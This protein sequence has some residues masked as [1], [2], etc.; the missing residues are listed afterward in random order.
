MLVD[1]IW[2]FNRSPTVTKLSS[3]F[4]RF[5]VRR[6]KLLSQHGGQ[7]AQMLGLKRCSIIGKWQAPTLA[8]M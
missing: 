4:V 3:V 6:F 2:V 5:F 8:A 1:Q 7:L